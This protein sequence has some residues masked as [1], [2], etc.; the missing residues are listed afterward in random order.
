MQGSKFITVLMVFTVAGFA[1]ASEKKIHG[2]KPR[3]PYITVADGSFS[4]NGTYV[5]LGYKFT[6]D[7]GDSVR[8][9][10]VESGKLI[11]AARGHGDF[12]EFCQFLGDSNRILS[13]DGEGKALLHELVVAKG[14]AASLKLL[15]EFALHE[16]VFARAAVS[17]NGRF[18]ITTGGEPGFEHFI[19][20]VWDLEKGE[21]I[22]L[23]DEIRS[24]YYSAVRLSPDGSLALTS[25]VRTVGG[26]SIKPADADH[27][28]WDVKTEK[29]IKKFVGTEAG[30][31]FA[32]SADGSSILFSKT[33]SKDDRYDQELSLI[34]TKSLKATTTRK[35]ETNNLL[36]AGLRNPAGS[37]LWIG[38]ASFPKTLDSAP[39]IATW[40]FE[41]SKGPKVIL[42]DNG[43]YSDD[44]IPTKSRANVSAIVVSRDGKF[45]LVA[46]G[47]NINERG[48]TPG[49]QVHVWNV[50]TEKLICSWSDKNPD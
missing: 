49:M 14:K 10:E 11:A 42:L 28:L 2:P 20:K 33:T 12:M 22:I 7:R 19:T 44:T 3:A 5:A 47:V 45:G 1:S 27:Y 18:L 39:G 50:T 48:H 24:H 30:W 26:E 29:L 31:P 34:D 41:S 37:K 36:T 9:W 38:Q 15:K 43:R 13:I 32:F 8:V 16:G 25:G 35:N 40:D 23:G 46:S 4:H 17:N 21:V 6:K